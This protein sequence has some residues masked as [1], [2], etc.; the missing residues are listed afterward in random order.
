ME[1]T[2]EVYRVEAEVAEG[3][4]RPALLEAIEVLVLL[5]SPFSP[6][7]AEEMWM[8]LGRPFSIVDRS[9]PTADAEAAREDAIELAVQVNGKVRGR[10]VVPRGASEESVRGAALAEPKVREHLDGRAVIKVVVVP[11]RLVSLVVR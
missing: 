9:W 10:I 2:N 8:K 1:L 11:E 3:A 4:G 5:L 6:H 7:V